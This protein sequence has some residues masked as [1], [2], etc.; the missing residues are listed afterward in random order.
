MQRTTFDEFF[1]VESANTLTEGFFEDLKGFVDVT[2][3]KAEEQS[4][5]AVSRA[6]AEV[7]GLLGGPQAADDDQADRGRV[8]Q[9]QRRS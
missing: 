3:H 5:T 1:E 6:R 7:D 2:N 4:L 9:S 8:D